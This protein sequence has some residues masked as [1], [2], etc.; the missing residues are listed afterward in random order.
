MIE[1]TTSQQA[2][3]NAEGLI[4]LTAC[5]GSGKTTVVAHRLR[6]LMEKRQLRE[7]QGIAVLSFTNVA[8]DSI[9]QMYYELTGDQVKG[10]HFV[11]TIDSFLNGF[12]IRVT[13]HRLLEKKTQ[14]VIIL[15]VN[16]LWIDDRFPKLKQFGLSGQNI[17]HDCSGNV[18]YQQKNKT[19][20]AEAQ[21]YLVVVKRELRKGNIITQG[22]VSYY[23]LEILRSFPGFTKA[24]CNRFPFIIVDEAQD[25]SET[26]MAII[27]EL[28]RQGH[29]EIM[30][31]GDP[32]QSIYEWRDANPELIIAKDQDGDWQSLSIT[33]TQRC[34]ES[35]C[36][37][38]NKFHNARSITQDT[39]R[40]EISDAEV[41][42]RQADDFNNAL[43]EFVAY[44]R[45]KGIMIGPDNV[46]IL[47]GGHRS[48]ANIR[49]SKI[50][51][52]DLFAVE[53]SDIQALPLRAKIHFDR[54]EYKQAYECLLRFLY[55][56]SKGER[57]KSS[58][59]LHDHKLGDLDSKW[60][61]WSTC[62]RLPSLELSLLEWIREVNVV[63]NEA[64]S[65]IGCRAC[66][67]KKKRNQAD[68][69]NLNKD[70]LIEAD[71]AEVR[72]ITIQNIHQIKGRT[73]DAVMIYVDS[74]R[75]RWKLTV[76]KIK[77]SLTQHDLFGSDHLDDTRCFY[78]AASR[79][80][81]VLWICSKDK[82]IETIFQPSK[83]GA[84]RS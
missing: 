69:N 60:L 43:A 51:E 78:V 74:G 7:Y 79:A 9:R 47:Y 41:I 66:E 71:E 48:V 39:N 77:E 10:P 23:C 17:C 80:R 73:F 3:V 84:P 2:A 55:F 26:Q 31:L 52:T 45:D 44:A 83:P 4:V 49:K 20:S 64:T 76:S 32:Y 62:K 42:A 81:K 22:D 28:K 50:K 61:I 35:I 54:A 8:K 65:E 72:E 75:G 70:L 59:Q 12:V 82:A 25:C 56:S 18:I 1:L 34:G 6:H 38:L 58:R 40:T 29:S 36:Q 14:K 19:I 63:L 67:L 16:S 33:E 11:G 13:G 15:D 21:Q 57:V 68:L 27:D 30:L 5:P 46:A 37:F 53:N 24:L